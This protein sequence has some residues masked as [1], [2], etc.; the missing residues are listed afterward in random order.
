MNGTKTQDY[1]IAKNV[2]KTLKVLN[3]MTVS[4]KNIRAFRKYL[5]DLG[6]YEGMEFKTEVNEDGLRII[7]SK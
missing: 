3:D 4:V 1:Q 2:V 7:R 5:Y 6:R